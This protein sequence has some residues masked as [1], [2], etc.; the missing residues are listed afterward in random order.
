MYIMSLVW[1]NKYNI[2]YIGIHVYVH[3]AYNRL[4]ATFRS[5]IHVI[6][7]N[8][9]SHLPF[10][11]HTYHMY[12]HDMFRLSLIWMRAFTFIHTKLMYLC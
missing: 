2:M 1:A 12:K 4:C 5:I 11:I 10:Y 6:L 3:V 9:S 8:I 7:T